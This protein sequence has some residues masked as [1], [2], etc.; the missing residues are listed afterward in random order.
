MGGNQS[1]DSGGGISSSIGSKPLR[2]LYFGDNLEVMRKLPTEFVD[3]VYLDPPFKSDEDY[4]VF[5]ESEGLDPDEA[6]WTAF[7]DTWIWDEA[8]D[9]A[10]EAIEKNGTIQLATLTDALKASLGKSPMMAYIAN[11]GI[12]LTEI[13]RLL[14]PTGSLYL[15]CDP[16]AS[17][18]LKLVLDAIFGAT[19]FRSEIIWRRTGS[20]GKTKRWGQSTTQFFIIQNLMCSRGTVRGDPT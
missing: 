4:N 14:K 20:H 10:M 15:H 5:F 12:R 3:L 7:K 9:E 6:Q 8:S 17:H 16:T 19:R 18:Y 11:M 2:R 13:Y 1:N